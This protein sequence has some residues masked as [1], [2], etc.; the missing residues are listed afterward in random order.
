MERLLAGHYRAVW[1]FVVRQKERVMT[2][3]LGPGG[4]TRYSSVEAV[5]WKGRCGAWCTR[6]RSSRRV[7]LLRAAGESRAE[8]PP[9]GPDAA[10]QRS[11][12]ST[13]RA[14]ATP[15]TAAHQRRPLCATAGPAWSSWRW[16]ELVHAPRG[17]QRPL[18]ATAQSTWSGRWVELDY[19]P[20]PLPPPLPCP[21]PPPTSGPCADTSFGVLVC[22]VAWCYLI[23]DWCFCVCNFKYFI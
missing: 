19:P 16:V 20:P 9:R 17:A 14:A 15:W 12:A 18:H 11:H 13:A 4:L 22:F 8:A 5:C 23:V 7:A 21:P 2:G 10:G 6:P 3:S 1:G